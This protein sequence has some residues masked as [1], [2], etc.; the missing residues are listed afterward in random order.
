MRDPAAELAMKIHEPFTV[1]A[2]G[3]LIQMQPF[4]K[5]ANEDT[6][7]LINVLNDADVSVA[8][9]ENILIDQYNYQGP[10]SD[11]IGANGVGEDIV[12]LGI[13]MVTKANNHTFDLGEEG[14][15]EN[16]RHAERVG[17]V[18]C[19]AGRTLAEARKARYFQSAKGLVGMTGVYV[20]DPVGLY[21]KTRPTTNTLQVHRTISV[22]NEQFAALKDIADSWNARSS[23]VPNPLVANVDADGGLKLFD[24]RFVASN[25]TGDCTYRMDEIDKAEILNAVKTGKQLSDY[26]IAQ[27]HWH[28]NRHTFQ[29]YTFDHYPTDYQQEIAHACVDAGADMVVGHGVH[30]IKG[31]E[32]Y[33]GRPICYGLSNFVF[34]QLISPYSWTSAGATRPWGDLNAERFGWL[35]GPANLEA[36]LIEGK[37][38]GGKLAQLRVHPVDLGPERVGSRL[39]IPELAKGEV[40]ERILEEVR[41][42]SRPF[43]TRIEIKDGIGVVSLH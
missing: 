26:F 22:T 43:G 32:I 15:W 11:I 16:L 39:G 4:T 23:E 36:L 33:Q 28:Q 27:F 38:D 25:S 30:T 42:F 2:V 37:Y 19:G 41:E 34:Q 18:H 35:G 13:D 6:R 20:T 9:M 40:A 8:N 3:D 1:A 12:A 14:L 5:Y 24:Q 17:L 10:M 31:I 7:H 21:S 29:R